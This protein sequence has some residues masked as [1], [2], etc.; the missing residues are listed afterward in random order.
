[1]LLP[2]NFVLVASGEHSRTRS[3]VV[4]TSSQSTR[5][6]HKNKEMEKGTGSALELES[7]ACCS[8]LAGA[9][10]GEDLFKL[11]HDFGFAFR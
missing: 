6:N 8:R 9:P 10:F 11:R 5:K 3:F 1:M 4:K 7:L 2:Y